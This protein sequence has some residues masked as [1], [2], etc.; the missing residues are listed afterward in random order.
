LGD[1][2]R[3]G[4]IPDDRTKAF[5]ATGNPS[6]A[7]IRILILSTP[8][9]G[10]TWL[11]NLLAAMY[12]L[13]KLGLVCPFDRTQ[14][15]SLGDRWILFHHFMPDPPI[16]EW[17]NEMQP[18]VLTTVRHPGDVL[19]S[20]YH[21]IHNFAAA[22]ID[23]RKVKAM[24]DSP[25]ER[26][27][28]YPP[29]T[30]TFRE[31][32]EC[33]LAWKRTGLSRIVR[34]EHLR[35]DTLRT[36]TSLANWIHPV[37][38]ARIEQAIERCDIEL[39]RK[40]HEEHRQFFRSGEVGQWK[41]GLSPEVLDFLATEP[42]RSQLAELGYSPG[43]QD[44]PPTPEALPARNPF[45]RSPVFANG[46]VVAPI[47]E[48]CYLSLDPATNA[49]WPPVGDVGPG[50][51]FSWLTGPSDLLGQGLYSGLP[52]SRLAHYIYR[53][54]PD[55]E[56][57]FPDLTGPDRLGYAQWFVRYATET[58]LNL[59]SRFVT[60]LD[61]DLS[62]WVHSRFPEDRMRRP[63]WPKL[64]NFTMHVYRSAPEL[65][66]DYPDYLVKDRWNLLHW[67]AYSHNGGPDMPG[68][69]DGIR[70]DLERCAKLRSAIGSLGLS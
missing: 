40:L 43:A 60:L 66:R 63:W 49:L 33:S 16:V 13:P 29:A 36:L 65:R 64:T 28:I 62:R 25:Y 26:H 21:H 68:F 39:M 5:R 22:S 18:F 30:H 11:L 56:R 2:R 47:I 61:D 55:L 46:A 34:Y 54:R 50:S 14:A 53:N 8:K 9:T 45:R 31:E 51:F 6:N 52:L 42:Y 4:G 12:D 19:I 58:P 17:I 35:L 67:L 20:L 44:Y 3:E 1:S 23:Q 48:A 7:Q 57:A 70:R 38:Q 32:L 27:G 41:G 24:L 15:S 69:K 37:K 59:D 10:N